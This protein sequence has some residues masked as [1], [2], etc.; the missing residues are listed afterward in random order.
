M[1]V[2]HDNEKNNSNGYDLHA[3]HGIDFFHLERVQFLQ[4]VIKKRTL[5]KYK[6]LN[7]I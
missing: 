2:S 3:D 5:N 1:V 7:P 4:L 6:M